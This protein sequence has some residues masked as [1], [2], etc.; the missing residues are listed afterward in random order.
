MSMQQ[1]GI[2]T[3]F[4][5]EGEDTLMCLVVEAD[6]IL[7]IGNNLSVRLD[8]V[9]NSS[10]RELTH[11][12]H[13]DE[14]L[15]S[16]VAA[17]FNQF[18]QV[19]NLMVAPVTDVRPRVIGIDNLPVYTFGCDAIRVIAI[20]CGCV[21][22]L[23]NDCVDVIGIRSRQRFPVLEYVTPV[24]LIS[25]ERFALLVLDT[26]IKTIPRPRRITMAA[27]E[28]QRQVLHEQAMQLMI[29]TID[30]TLL[31]FVT[32]Q[33]FGQRAEERFVL[34]VQC[35]VKHLNMVSK[36]SSMNRVFIGIVAAAHSVEQ[37][38]GKVACILRLVACGLQAVVVRHDAAQI[39]GGSLQ[40]F[41]H[42]LLMVGFIN[43]TKH[44]MHVC[45]IFLH[46]HHEHPLPTLA[47]SH[48]HRSV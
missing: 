45:S 43:L 21:E 32:T 23:C 22:E 47:G 24:A 5:N 9:R 38:V 8:A 15:R 19:D 10:K 3:I 16:M 31:K 2:L 13:V 28:R 41:E 1:T 14:C 6:G 4:G 17:K 20:G 11:I 27:R 30:D 36:V 40:C 39:G 48:V 37:H 25:D 44:L 18:A 26:D 46:I 33:L 7:R 34:F 12:K 29:H 42:N 35:M